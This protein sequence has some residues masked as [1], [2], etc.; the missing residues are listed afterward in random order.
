M[1]NK[2]YK[3]GRLQ[4]LG[5]ARLCPWGS[6]IN[7]KRDSKHRFS[8]LDVLSFL[9]AIFLY[10]LPPTP[11]YLFSLLVSS[12]YKRL[13]TPHVNSSGRVIIKKR[14]YLVWYLYLFIFVQIWINLYLIISVYNL[15]LWGYSS[16]VSGLLLNHALNEAMFQSFT[17]YNASCVWHD[18]Q[19][20]IWHDCKQILKQTLPWTARIINYSKYL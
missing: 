1:V 2:K 17:I 12:W 16:Q 10:L 9:L 18:N 5:R 6:Q 15:Y 3:R 8:H 11:H 4:V 14:I 19:H 20:N 13:A 7:G